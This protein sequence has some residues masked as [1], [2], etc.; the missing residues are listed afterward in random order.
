[1]AIYF[2]SKYAI[3]IYVACRCH[4]NGYSNNSQ[5]G[6]VNNTGPRNRQ[7]VFFVNSK[8]MKIALVAPLEES[9]PPKRY[10]GTE[11]V[12][13]WLMNELVRDGHKVTLFAT[14]DSQ[15]PKGVRLVP[16]ADKGLRY[17]G[18]EQPEITA[19]T[20]AMLHK[21]RS[22][23][24][25]YDVIHCHLGIGEQFLLPK[26]VR[27]KMITT[28]HWRLDGDGAHRLFDRFEVEDEPLIAISKS[29]QG[30]LPQANWAGVVYHG[31]PKDE[32]HLN[33]HPEDYL[34]FIGRF[35]PEKG[36]F[37]AYEIARRAGMK[38]KVAAKISKQD[39]EYYEREIRPL[40]ASNQ[41][42][43]IG[44]IGD[45][46]KQE[47]IGNAKALLF[48]ILWPEPFGLVMIEAMAC[49][50]PVV[51]FNNGSVP[52]VLDNNVTGIVLDPHPQDIG[53]S[54]T[55]AAKILREKADSF[56]RKKIRQVFEER[57][58]AK[59]MMHDYIALYKQVQ[60]D[61]KQWLEEHHKY[62]PKKSKKVATV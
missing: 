54:Y 26:K 18:A 25:H 19:H 28:V 58:K 45:E 20:I 61:H 13:W 14:A 47:F 2:F 46:Q 3:H 39:M 38:L 43:Y 40:I 50:T 51:A 44:E 48:P 17:L 35:S 10:G 60:K 31:L 16:C 53:F 33:E 23:A 37:G 7:Q 9:V 49:G 30:Y 21:V 24:Q 22:R 41:V 27:A 5:I 55:D 11:R 1:M 59:R 15:V 62:K 57:F 4:E 36:F 29:Q 32:Y 12:I 8:I 34:A 52:E 56:D 6:E 42:E